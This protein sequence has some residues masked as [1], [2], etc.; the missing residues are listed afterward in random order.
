MCENFEKEVV[1]N[2]KLAKEWDLVMNVFLKKLR[3]K[4]H[5]TKKFKP[6]WLEKGD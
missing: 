2:E 5:T 1:E 6:F 4:W 3:K